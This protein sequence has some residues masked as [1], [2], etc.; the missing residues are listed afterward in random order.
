MRGTL[1]PLGLLGMLALLGAAARAAPPGPEAEAAPDAVE[2]AEDLAALGLADEA[3]EAFA[4]ALRG[5][6]PPEAAKRA[7]HGIAAAEWARGRRE[8]AIAAWRELAAL[9]P[10]EERA[11]ALHEMRARRD[12]RE[13]RECEAALAALAGRA[14]LSAEE[15]AEVEATAAWVGAQLALEPA[16]D[17]R[18]DGG[19]SARWLLSSP[20]AARAAGRRGDV[21]LR[22]EAAGGASW[23]V[24]PAPWRGGPCV[25]TCDLRVAE[26]EAGAAVRIGLMAGLPGG[27][28]A[29]DRV[30]AEIARADVA[31]PV[32]A[33][34]ARAR[35]AL[36]A[37]AGARRV[38]RAAPS[39]D[40]GIALDT[41]IRVRVEVMPALARARLEVW[42]RALAESGGAGPARPA[43]AVEVALPAPFADATYFFGALAPPD[44]PEGAAAAIVLED[45]RLLVPRAEAGAPAPPE[46]GDPALVAAAA[47]AAL[48]SGRAADAL[49]GY[50]A[51]TLAA[52][53]SGS[54]ITGLGLAAREAG[55]PVLAA[56][57]FA[58]VLRSE[59]R[60]A[61]HFRALAD[62][63]A[64]RGSALDLCAA[65]EASL[66]VE[67]ADAARRAALDG[68][69]RRLAEAVDAEIEP[70][71]GFT[72]ED[73]R[74]RAELY[75]RAAEPDRA[76]AELSL[77]LAAAPA[78]GAAETAAPPA[79]DAALLSLRARALEAKGD[80]GRA[81]ID[82]ARARA[83][84]PLDPAPLVGIARLLLERARRTASG[85]SAP[86][87]AAPPAGDRPEAAAEAALGRALLLVGEPPAFAEGR[88]A[89]EPDPRTALAAQAHALR[90]EARLLSPA[91]LAEAR[92]DAERA[93]LL[94]P[95]DPKGYELLARVARAE[96]KL[97]DARSLVER[98]ALLGPVDA[99]FAASVGARR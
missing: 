43:T 49:A 89:I 55:D 83:A 90:A 79:P 76:L 31:E 80:P 97:D 85:D 46:A 25:F 27:P 68:A 33:G 1:A 41:P 16:L 39:S 7:R 98:A 99:A 78:T 91:R 54:A 10:E 12:L 57:A 20:L 81:A 73:R 22:A 63:I 37:V 26:I 48:A 44:E 53:F 45:A 95:R 2:V 69:R 51:A 38:S 87:G 6:P 3:I 72:A 11:V 96:G 28:I 86:P 93:A 30:Y 52:P 5:A 59:P 34:P 42:E 32:D 67:P 47:N 62:E 74:R 9:H 23:L 29:G 77:A 92:A 36:A 40:R 75:I 15:R 61:E 65:L 70:G 4:D 13:W 21:E 24:T 60:A 17:E 58:A 84:A 14:D 94:A 56:R 18:F 66:A 50:R 88:S 64:A 82:W 35:A 8:E 71:S 19:L